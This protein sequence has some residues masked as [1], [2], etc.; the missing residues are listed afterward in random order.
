MPPEIY[1]VDFEGNELANDVLSLSGHES[2]KA[3]DYSLCIKRH[4]LTL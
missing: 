4:L 3:N 2:F 1:V